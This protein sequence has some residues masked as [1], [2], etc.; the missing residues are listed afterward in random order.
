MVVHEHD[1][2][3]RTLSFVGDYVGVQSVSKIDADGCAEARAIASDYLKTMCAVS[4]SAVAVSERVIPRDKATG[5]RVEATV[6]PP[7]VPLRG[8]HPPTCRSNK[9]GRSWRRSS[10][11]HGAEMRSQGQTR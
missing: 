4:L 5:P 1:K 6:T 11:K 10:L 7:S 2:G 9:A 3:W 8:S